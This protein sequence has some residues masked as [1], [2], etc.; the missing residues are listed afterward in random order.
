MLD[1]DEIHG[2]SAIHHGDESKFVA[3]KKAKLRPKSERKKR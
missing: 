3:K 2:V 1:G